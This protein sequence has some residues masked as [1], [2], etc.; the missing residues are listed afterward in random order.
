MRCGG[1]NSSP[2]D[3]SLDAGC[4]WGPYQ[5]LPLI[6]GPGTAGV[7]YPA[8]CTRNVATPLA[9]PQRPKRVP[10]FPDFS[11]ASPALQRAMLL[12]PPR[13]PPR[14]HSTYPAA[15]Y[16]ALLIGCYC[17]PSD[18]SRTHKLRRCRAPCQD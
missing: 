10:S 6:E 4:F 7:E 1:L 17:S 5:H 14:H 15:T 8:W 9:T 2:Q 12:R 11:P 13:T 18:P 3:K 16:T